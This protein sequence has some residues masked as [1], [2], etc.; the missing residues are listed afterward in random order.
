MSAPIEG[1]DTQVSKYSAELTHVCDVMDDA[2]AGLE[3]RLVL[4]I[5]PFIGNTSIEASE[6]DED[7][8][9]HAEFLR[10]RVSRLDGITRKI[11][12]ICSRIEI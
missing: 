10:S 1:R 11:L 2:I 5:A 3:K 6:K 8:V 9:P 7:L 4:I 12:D